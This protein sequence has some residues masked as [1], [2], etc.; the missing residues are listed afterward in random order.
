MKLFAWGACMFLLLSWLIFMANGYANRPS[1]LVRAIEQVESKGSAIAIGDNGQAVGILQIHPVMVQD[2]NRI[3]GEE[4]FDL[5]D[6]WS[7]DKSRQMFRVY[8]EH[9]SKGASDEV[10]AR[11]WNGGPRGDTNPNTES[12]WEKVR[13]EVDRISGR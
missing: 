9:Y 2:C 7:V 12:Y 3:L 5:E 4:K 6:R 8:T 10:V 13:E 1:L 11:R